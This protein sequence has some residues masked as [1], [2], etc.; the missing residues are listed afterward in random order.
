MAWTKL[1][2]FSFARK[3]PQFDLMIES[4]PWELGQG[5]TSVVIARYDGQGTDTEFPAIKLRKA[6]ELAQIRANELGENVRLVI[7]G[8]YSD[9][10]DSLL[11]HW[12]VKD[13][14][15][16]PEYLIGFSST[17]SCCRELA[18]K[19]ITCRVFGFNQTEHVCDN[20]FRKVYAF[21]N[22]KV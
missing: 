14:D 7:D 12:G 13:F 21:Y 8:Y 19:T 4:A 18:T 10:E 1:E 9:G 17:C 2:L 5:R 16:E 20:H 3:C 15:S 11:G 6:F 22:K